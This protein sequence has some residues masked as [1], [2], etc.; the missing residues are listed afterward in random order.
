MHCLEIILVP[1]PE[2]IEDR[3]DNAEINL[4]LNHVKEAR[5]SLEEAGKLVKK[6]GPKYS[7]QRYFLLESQI[8]EKEKKFETAVSFFEAFHEEYKKNYNAQRNRQVLML[9]EQFEIDD[10]EKELQVQKL[11]ISKQRMVR[12]FLILILL[13]ISLAS[14]QFFKRY[15][16]LFSFWKKKNHVGKYRLQEKIGSGAMGGIYKAYDV[17]HK[18]KPIAIKVL[19]EEYGQDEEFKRRFKNE[20]SILDQ[21]N[22]PN[23]VHVYERGEYEHHFYIAMELIEGKKLAD[24][25]EEGPM[26]LDSIP[27]IMLQIAD[28]LKCIHKRGIIHRD[29]KPE[30]IMIKSSDNNPYEVKILDFGLAQA[31]TLT[32]LTQTGYIMGTVFYLAPERLMSQKSTPASDIY[33]FGV[34]AYQLLAGEQPFFAESNAAVVNQIMKAKP[35]D[36]IKFRPDTPKPLNTL[37]LKMLSKNSTHRPTAQQIINH[38]KK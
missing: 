18:E 19:K 29:L 37:I 35:I 32:K 1:P 23:I 13:L 7:K 12:H 25:M 15:R 30:N 22:H 31:Q 17:H 5:S 2:N 34:I 9:Q 8:N 27:T 21:I 36:P 20:G 14:V 3:L 26:D 38:L 24:L 16:H 28:A 4:K 33:A 6:H 10:K 11:T